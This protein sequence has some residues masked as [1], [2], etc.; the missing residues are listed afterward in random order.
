MHRLFAMLSVAAI[1]YAAPIVATPV[2]QKSLGGQSVHYKT[3]EEG[4]WPYPQART[5]SELR[6]AGVSLP[7]SRDGHWI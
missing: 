7:P 2:P 3:V 6:N 1:V 5:E 4:I